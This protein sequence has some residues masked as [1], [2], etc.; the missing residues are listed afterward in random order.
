M[1]LE[2][3]IMDLVETIKIG[4][5]KEYLELFSSGNFITQSDIHVHL[6][7]RDEEL[8]KENLLNKTKIG[9]IGLF[10][11]IL[12]PRLDL[13]RIFN[14]FIPDNDYPFIQYQ[15]PDGQI[16]FKYYDAYMAEFTKTNNN[17]EMI[18]K[19]FE[20]SPYGISFKVRLPNDNFMAI[21][22][23]DIGKVEYKTQWKE[24][25]FANIYDVI[26]TYEYVKDLVVRINTTLRYHPHNISIRVPDNWE[27]NF[28]FINCIQKFKLPDNKII[29]HNDLF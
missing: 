11:G 26:D 18:T 22:I 17:V 3:E 4:N 2:K 7:I 16:I 12:I 1:V 29:N 15:V 13:F 5:R 21:N 24:T 19:W 28:A 23:N 9:Q 14:D 27:F 20:N 6:D 8:E 25:D 10:S